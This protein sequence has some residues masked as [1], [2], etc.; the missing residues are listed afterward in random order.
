MI[1]DA[2]NSMS[3]L[4]EGYISMLAVARIASI[5]NMPTSSIKTDMTFGVDLIATFK[6]DFR[7]NEL[8]RVYYDIQNAANREIYKK[9][10]R[11]EIE[12]QTVEDYCKYMIYCYHFNPNNVIRIL[13]SI[14]SY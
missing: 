14:N 1:A 11:G 4:S 12:I 10:E 2:N 8:D 3:M 9:L 5:F 6:S 13:K 7:E